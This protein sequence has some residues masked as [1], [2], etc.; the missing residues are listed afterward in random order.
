MKENTQSLRLGN[1][2]R[3]WSVMALLLGLLVLA[4]VLNMNIG[5]V[6]IRPGEV[7]SMLWDGL[8][9][10]ADASTENQILFRIRIPRMLLA[11]ILGGALSVSGYLLQVFFRNPIAGPFVLGI[12]SGAK[13]VVGITLIFLVRYLGSVSPVTLILAAFAGSLLITSVVL[14]FAQKVHSM[15]MLLV[16]GIMVDRKSVV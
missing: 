11:A 14:V 16:I 4:L 8:R 6:S 9:G 13:M 1:P 15:S 10:G 7:L 5:T 2:G 3:F 12:S